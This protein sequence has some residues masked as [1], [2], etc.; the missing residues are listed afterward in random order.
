MILYNIKDGNNLN[1]LIIAE[2]Q[3][4]RDWMNKSP[5]AYRC[6]PLTISNEYGWDILLPYDLELEWDGTIEKEGLRIINPINNGVKSH[7][8][9][10][11]VTFEPGFNIKTKKDVF[12]MVCPVSNEFNVNFI[13]LSAIIETDKLDYPWFLTIKILKTGITKIE[14]NTRIARIFPINIKYSISE[15]IIENMMP[16]DRKQKE[17]EF[18]DKRSQSIKEN[19]KWTKQYINMVDYTK[20]KMKNE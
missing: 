6:T 7:F 3:R 8:G 13:P 10:G 4:A 17:K 18:A 15:L 2:G 14:K 1:K 20:I 16:D 12:T 11:T 9:S 19:E 5:H